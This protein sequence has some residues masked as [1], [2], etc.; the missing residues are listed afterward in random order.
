MTIEMKKRTIHRGVGITPSAPWM[1]SLSRRLAVR[2]LVEPLAVRGL[3]RRGAELR[4]LDRLEHLDAPRVDAVTERSIYGLR[5]LDVHDRA[6][7]ADQLARKASGYWRPEAFGRLD[8][9]REHERLRLGAGARLVVAREREK[10]DEA[11]Q[12]REAGRE[13]AEHSGRAVAVA[14]ATALRGAVPHEQHGADG[15]S[16]HGGDDER[17]PDDVHGCAVPAPSWSDRR[18][19]ASTP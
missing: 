4:R 12:H 8:L 18:Q 17:R 7:V 3:P 11:E 9:L 15:H 2:A 14:E 13:H 6:A 19:P 1:R 16:R 5:P 10:D